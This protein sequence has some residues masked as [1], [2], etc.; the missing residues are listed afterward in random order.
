MF[1]KTAQ[2][3]R[4]ASFYSSHDLDHARFTL[5]PHDYPYRIRLSSFFGLAYQAQA[6]SAIPKK[7]LRFAISTFTL[8]G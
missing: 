7:E 1:P 4:Q 6:L 5:E 2:L 8:S 3:L